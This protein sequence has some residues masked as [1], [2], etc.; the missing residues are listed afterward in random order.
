MI[1]ISYLFIAKR[2]SKM[3]SSTSRSSSMSRS[4]SRS[5]GPRRRRSPRSKSHSGSGDEGCGGRGQDARRGS[6]MK[7]RSRKRRPSRSEDQDTPS[8]PQSNAL[9][10]VQHTRHATEESSDSSEDDNRLEG[11]DESHSRNKRF[12]KVDVSNPLSKFRKWTATGSST[13]CL[14]GSSGTS[15]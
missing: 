2:V 12:R 11:T 3:S 13:S 7:D 1:L 4:C 15:G 14:P 6:S 10:P 8:R 5:R 9:V